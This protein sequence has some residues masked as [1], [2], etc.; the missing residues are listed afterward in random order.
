VGH[1][2]LADQAVDGARFLQRVE[3]L[4]LDVLDERH[5]HRGLVGHDADDGGHVVQAGHLRRPPAALA[6]DDLVT[7]RLAG[8]L[9]RQRRTTIGWTTPWARIESA[10][11]CRLSG[12]MSRR[13]W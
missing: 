6:G 10:S 7:Q 8:A 3:I 5:R 12:R 2:E 4:A 13:G 1:V 11:S 9:R